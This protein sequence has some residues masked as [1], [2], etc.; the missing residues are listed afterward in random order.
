MTVSTATNNN[1]LKGRVT[2]AHRT[3]FTVTMAE[4]NEVTATVRG[5]FHA[6]K[7]FLRLETMFC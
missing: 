6:D 4:G 5:V 2:E 7:I 1:L 3:N